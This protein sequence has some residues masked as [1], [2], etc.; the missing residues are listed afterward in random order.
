MVASL[1]LAAACGGDDDGPADTPPDAGGRP[2]AAGPGVDAGGF[3]PCEPG[4]EGDG[5]PVELGG[6][7]TVRELRADGYDVT[8][9][10]FRGGHRPLPRIARA[11]VVRLVGK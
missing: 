9:R 5:I 4:Y 1:I 2:D 3:E 11:F 7:W 6:D 8:Y 10:R